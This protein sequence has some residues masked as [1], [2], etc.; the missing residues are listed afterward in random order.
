MSTTDSLRWLKQSVFLNYG[1][2]VLAVIIALFIARLIQVQYEFE[3]FV[4]FI[5]AMMFSTWYGGVK[6]GLLSVALSLLAFH[7]YLLIPH[8]PLGLEKEMP[9][10]LFAGLTSVLIVLLGAAQRDATEALRESELHLRQIAE[11]IREVFWMATRD[12]DV[13]LYVS[14]AYDSIWGRSVESL[15]QQPRAFFDA[16]HPEDR[17]HAAAIIMGQREQEIDIEYRIVRPDGTLRWIRDHR[18]PVRDASGT[19]CRIAG[20]AEDITE[21]KL[22]ELALKQADDHLR[23]VLDTTPGQIHTGRP[24][25]YLDYFNQ[26]WLK[27][28]GLSLE[29]LQGWA[30]T[31]AIHPQDVEEIVKKWRECLA[32]GEL[33]ENESRVRRADGEYRWMLHRKVP[34]RDEHGIIV[35]WYGLS[36][37]IEDRKQAE[38]AL[39]K[40]ESRLREAE[41]LANIGYWERDLVADRITWSDETYRIW[42]CPRQDRGLSQRELEE[43]IHP[44]DRQL[45]RQVLTEAAKGSQRY[46]VEYRIVRPDGEIRFVNVRDDIEYGDAGRPIRIFGTVQ[47]IT[48]RKRAEHALREAASQLEALSRRLVEL[49][50]SERKELARELHDR[51]GQNLTALNINLKILAT[52]L[53][54]QAS[55]ELRVR[56]VD[57][58]ALVESTAAAIR[59]VMSELRPPMLDDQ[60]L[61]P[62][63]DWYAKQFSERTGIAVGVR[64]L[65]SAERLAPEMEIALF[66]VAQEAL[67]NVVKHARASQVEIVLER[68]GSDYVM[69]VEDDG[70]GFEAAE[71]FATRQ[72]GLGM[73]TMRERTQAL[74]GKLEVQAGRGDGTRLTVRVPA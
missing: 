65:V 2:A 64:G 28:V 70:V 69:T 10:L 38:E 67:N 60:G 3:P 15:R 20:V 41:Q 34:L 14:P 37:D 16:I 72:A 29:D 51:I 9:R 44:D 33:F 32:S 66:R 59:N 35:K 24:D 22:A 23:L 53:P 27:Y 73:V 1:V 56:L 71:I 47:D 7:F 50:E 63:L 17:E 5:L 42:G 57:S 36:T 61:E 31:A 52:A 62:A 19:V 18:F 11:N 13:P 48:E 46:D 26:R 30:W 39:R 4:L 6:P 25:G 54:P 8:Y 21:R 55:D 12:L 58:E 40:S 74:G 68:S 45:Q 43:T 49:Q